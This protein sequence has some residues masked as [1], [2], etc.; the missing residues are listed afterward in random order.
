[1]PSLIFCIVYNISNNELKITSV[2]KAYFMLWN[3]FEI[4]SLSHIYILDNKIGF[5]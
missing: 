5:S 3:F 2:K 4:Y 1:M